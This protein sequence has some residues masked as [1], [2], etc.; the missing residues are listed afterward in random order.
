M[1]TTLL[2]V[3]RSFATMSRH[4]VV[5][6]VTLISGNIG[7]LTKQGLGGF[8]TLLWTKEP[9]FLILHSLALISHAGGTWPSCKGIKSSEGTH[10][11]FHDSWRKVVAACVFSAM[12]KE[13]WSLATSCNPRDPCSSTPIIRSFPLL[14]RLPFFSSDGC[15]DAGWRPTGYNMVSKPHSIPNKD[16]K[17]HNFH[18][19]LCLHPS[20]HKAIREALL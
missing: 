5:S 17:Q 14:R 15:H 4:I 19:N 6:F 20:N 16:T 9:G 18:R 13:K 3:G 2:L 1:S 11:H 8:W 7:S 12:W 10:V